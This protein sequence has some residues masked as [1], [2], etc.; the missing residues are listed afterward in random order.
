MGA[1]YPELREGA[2]D[3]R[4]RAQGRGGA[5]RRDAGPRHAR[6]RRGG[7]AG[8]TARFAGADA[9]RLYDTY[10]FPVDLTADIARERGLDGRHGRLRDRRWSAQRERA[11]AASKFGGGAD[12][13]ADA[14]KDL[15]ATEFTG[16]E[17]LAA[18][19]R[20]GRRHPAATAASRAR[21]W[22]TASRGVVILDRTPFYAESGG[23]VGDRG[24][25]RGAD[26]RR[27]EVDDTAQAAR[28]L[29]RPHRHAGAARSRCASAT[30]VAAPVDAAR[31]QATV[32]NHSATH[33][34]HAAL[35]EVLGEHVQQKGSLV[36]PDRLRFDFSH[37]QPVDAE[38][39]ARDRDAWSTTRS[40]ANAAAEAREMGYQEA[41][42]AGAMALFGE[43]Y[44]ERVRVL[45]HGR[46]LDRAVRRHPRDAHRRHRP[47][48]DRVGVGRG[49]RRA[50]HRGG[51]RRRRAGPGRAARARAGRRRSPARGGSR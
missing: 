37:F 7:R 46:L 3:R 48:Q 43:K 19:R 20:A 34:L 50:P 39:L 33:L 32:L 4:A 31:R 29:P 42:G 16:Y 27:F 25:L 45:Q 11:R 36:A 51:D 9:F 35:R 47:V 41:I 30:A 24:E 49:R 18:G 8:A 28:Q 22:P 2:V 15:P 14:V 23:Q 40:A 6:V 13:A 44:G 26:G 10:G 38:E 21:R 5:L 1:A 12:I 17:R